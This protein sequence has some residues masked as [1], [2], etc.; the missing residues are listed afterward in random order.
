MMLTFLVSSITIILNSC[1]VQQRY[2][3]KGFN[4]DWKNTSLK[5]K[6]SNNAEVFYEEISYENDK[7]NSY[8][9]HDEASNMSTPN[10]TKT[11]ENDLVTNAI[12]VRDENE[13]QELEKVNTKT[14]NTEISS[15]N[16]KKIKKKNLLKKKKEIKNPSSAGDDE[17][18]YS[19][20]VA[21]ILC[22]LVGVLGIH[23]FYLGHIGIGVLYLL[24]GGLCGIGVLIDFILLLTGGLKPKNGKY[25]DGDSGL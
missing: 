14:T 10:L 24:T 3:R 1:S 12:P 23:R 11:I 18:E 7:Q 22:I 9:K 5:I 19:W 13:K 2:H 25:K 21:L 17:N 20:M 16:F 15:S 4:V 8:A 6:K